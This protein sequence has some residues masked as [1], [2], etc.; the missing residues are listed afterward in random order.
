M[1][2][3]RYGKL[4]ELVDG[5]TVVASFSSI[6]EAQDVINNKEINLESST[7]NK[8]NP[9]AY[10]HKLMGASYV[11]VDEKNLD[12]LTRG[13]SRRLDNNVRVK[14]CQRKDFI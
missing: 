5:V 8:L 3:K 11:K 13:N 14:K 1:V 12:R 4:F 2:I 9:K 7:D 10:S 6:E